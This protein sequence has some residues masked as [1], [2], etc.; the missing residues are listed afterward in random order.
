MNKLLGSAFLVT[1]MAAVSTGALAAGASAE[2]PSS[3]RETR[4]I[5]ARVSKVHLGSVIQLTLHQGATPSLVLSGDPRYVSRITTV[6]QGDTL[7]IGMQDTHLDGRHE[8]LRADVTVPNLQE[9]VAAG[10]GA[11]EVSGFSG[12]RVS[13]SADGVGALRF[14]GQYREVNANRGGVGAMELHLGQA[15]R[16][17]LKLTGTGQISAAGQTRMLRADI[18]GVGGLDAQQ[19]HAENVDLNM[20]GLG[21]ASVYAKTAA[22]VNLSGMGSATV[23]GNPAKR[24]QTTSG[25]G[26]ISWQ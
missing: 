20:T 6:Q 12:D 19:L 5:D 7:T 13:L 23:Y 22:N 3:A 24:T 8:Q 2:S 10:V 9:F 15:E 11:S 17:E 16:V 18:G 14:T 4:S 21:S 25:F 26:K 1:A